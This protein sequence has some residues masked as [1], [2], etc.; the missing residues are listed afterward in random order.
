MVGTETLASKRFD[1]ADLKAFKAFLIEKGKTCVHEPAGLLKF[2]FVTPSY[3]VKAGAD[4]QAKVPARS[5]VGHYLQMYDWDACFFSQAHTEL[6]LGDLASSFV[7]N[8]LNLKEADGYVPRTI[9]P[10]S[11]WDSGDVCKPFLS[12][13]LLKGI[14]LEKIKL[15]FP[16]GLLEDLECY[17]NYFF[18]NR[19]HESGLFHWRNVLE[20]GVDDNVALIA[21]MEAA[22][23][24]NK[25][26][27]VFIDGKVLATDLNSYLVAEYTAFSKIAECSGQPS[28]ANKYARHASDLANLVEE[29]LWS[30]SLQLYCNLD[31]DTKNQINI[32]SWTGLAPVLCGFARPDRAKTVIEQN[33]LHPNHFLRPCGLPSL[34][35]SELLYNQAK[36]GLYS[37]SLVS[38][39][40]GP[41][42]VLPNI[43]T[44]RALLQYGYADQAKDMAQRVLSTLIADWKA[45]GTI[46]ENYNAETGQPLWAPQFMSWNILSL[47]LIQLVA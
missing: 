38:N 11:I 28:L 32:R 17:L 27:G 12:Q 45:T 3:Q 19:R 33:I 8:F 30:E 21:P 5:S 15:T 23:D 29:Y 43:L 31:P 6:G 24:E 46:H 18:R 25:D 2:L 9:S 10:N 37:R 36:R 22:K 13:A 40:Q 1:T 4:D 16:A 26:I 42:W 34:A 14:D 7:R 20:S 47:E 35:A 44:V 39:W 41:M